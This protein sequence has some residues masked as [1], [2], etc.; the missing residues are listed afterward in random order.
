MLQAS[1][2]ASGSADFGL[3]LAS[4][5]VCLLKVSRI[6]TIDSLL[7][8]ML[9]GSTW[10]QSWVHRTKFVQDRMYSNSVRTSHGC[11]RDCFITASC[12]EHRRCFSMKSVSNGASQEQLL[13]VLYTV[14]YAVSVVPMTAAVPFY[15]T[16]LLAS[17]A[18]QL[19]TASAS[20]TAPSNTRSCTNLKRTNIMVIWTFQ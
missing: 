10:Q 12:N 9:V 3:A 18:A 19:C 6:A 5:C 11:P 8:V 17:Y 1:Y 13:A 14:L 20:S 2:Q 4:L 15:Y 16:T 7:A